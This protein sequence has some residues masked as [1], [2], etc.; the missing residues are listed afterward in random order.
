MWDAW[1][2]MRCDAMGC[3]MSDTTYEK[4]K[5]AKCVMHDV[6]CRMCDVMWY[7]MRWRYLT[8]RLVW[9]YIWC[10]AVCDAWCVM[11]AWCDMTLSLSHVLHVSPFL[12]GNGFLLRSYISPHLSFL[13]QSFYN[14][15]PT[16]HLRSS[17]FTRSSSSG[18]VRC[19]SF[20]HLLLAIS[21]ALRASLP[22]RFAFSRNS[23]GMSSPATGRLKTEKQ[24][25]QNKPKE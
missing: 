18:T 22:M 13:I 6:W 14:T 16:Q 17:C 11:W 7:G 21:F 2:V 5:A 4:R 3:E 12:S 15:V 24:A 19:D 20:H 8:W 1:H 23:S 10:D 25:K 9:C